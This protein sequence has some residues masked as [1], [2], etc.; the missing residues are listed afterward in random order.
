M[1]K[2]VAV[3]GATGVAG[4]QFVSALAD[5]P[6]F[7]IAKLAGSTRSAGKTYEES[8]KDDSG[9]ILWWQPEAIPE[10]VRGM[11]VEDSAT[12]DLSRIDVVFTAFDSDTA[13]ELEPKYA[14]EKPV[15]STASAFRMTDDVPLLVPGVNSD[16]ARLIAEQKKK[17]GWRGFIAPI[18]NCTTYGL[19]CTLAPIQKA[20]GI[21]HV[22]MTSMQAV[23]GAGRVGG[24]LSLD[25]LDNVVPHIP[26]EE[27]KVEVETQKILGAV[28]QD[29]IKAA[30][31]GVSCTCT[32]VP[33]IDGH[34][35]AVFVATE[36]PATPDA[37]KKTLR[38][39][40]AGLE[41][42]PTAPR[43]FFVVHEDPFQPQPRRVREW[44]GGMPTHVG[45]IREEKVLGGLKYV[46][47]SHNT[48]AGAAKGAILVA[49]LLHRDGLLG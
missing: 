43:S 44:D 17:R 41:G 20:F 13:R 19:V 34:T 38:E 9:K 31:F 6:W 42:L 27:E 16:H 18:P 29:T 40:Q 21:K 10:S 48:K 7:E 45:R 25:M 1:K 30:G 37:F 47:L 32:R 3:V 12:L 35:E 36:R 14:K 26:G 46:L 39:W 24:V 15:I 23:S 28:S 11:K 4:Q 33:V 22:L 49:E 5:H 2:K 8:L